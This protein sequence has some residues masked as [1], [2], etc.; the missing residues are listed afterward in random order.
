MSDYVYKD[1]LKLGAIE[2]RLSSKQH[3]SIFK[4]RQK[5]IWNKYEYYKYTN[6]I[7]ME[8]YVSLVGVIVSLILFP[9]YILR[10][11][12]KEISK[13]FKRLLN[14]KKTGAFTADW[15]SK[16]D[17]KGSVWYLINSIIEFKGEHK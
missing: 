13:E 17:D 4:Y 3:N 9:L 7:V 8:K 11:D 15:I 10:Y 16:S 14:Q 5:T 6:H 12:A 2:L 1:H